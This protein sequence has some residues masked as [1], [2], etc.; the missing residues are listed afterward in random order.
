MHPS[1][2]GGMLE[3]TKF[4]VWFFP[5][6]TKLKSTLAAWQEVESEHLFCETGAWFSLLVQVPDASVI[7]DFFSK[8]WSLL[9]GFSFINAKLDFKL[10]FSHS[11]WEIFLPSKKAETIDYNI[12]IPGA[13]LHFLNKNSR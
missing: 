6:S 7:F 13:V 11:F 10:L 1:V 4:I 5:H 2:G 12:V 9:C 8:C 3:S